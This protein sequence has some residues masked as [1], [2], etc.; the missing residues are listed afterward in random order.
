[1]KLAAIYNVWD[2]VELLRGSMRCLS[3]HV[4]VFIIVYQKVSNFGEAYDPLPDMDLSGFPCIMHEYVPPKLGG[5]TNEIQKRNIGI[6]LAREQGCTHF[7]HM[8][9][10]EY[11]LDFA[12]AKQE[13]LASGMEGSVCPLYCYFKR[14]TW[15]FSEPDGYFVPFIHQLG[16]ETRAIRANYPFYVDP[17]RRIN[18]K[19]VAKLSHFMHHFSWVRRDMERKARNS[20]AGD[21]TK[22][23]LIMEDYYSTALE[24]A[25]E[26][27]YAR[28]FD[29]KITVV[30][31]VFGIDSAYNLLHKI[32]LHEVYP[33]PR[34]WQ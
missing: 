32:I 34:H 15:R 4:N 24:Q 6:A 21:L 14:P 20:S 18:V 1:M 13:Y 17:T 16:P 8:D 31:D 22:N 7:L 27:F 26:G 28:N 12:A 33:K 5:A 10:D 3:G 19:T 30:E 2:G 29:R 23:K 9:C 25:P 11:Y